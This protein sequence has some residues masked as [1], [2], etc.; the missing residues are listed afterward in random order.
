MGEITVQVRVFGFSQRLTQARRWAI[1]LPTGSQVGDLLKHCRE[2]EGLELPENTVVI[3]NGH[4]VQQQSG[5]DT[6]L[7]GGDEVTL[8]KPVAGG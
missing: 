7:A 4:I 2:N 8:M 5:E 1:T 6:P 3:L